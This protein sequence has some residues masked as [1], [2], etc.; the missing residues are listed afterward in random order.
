MNRLVGGFQFNTTATVESGRPLAF[1]GG[2]SSPMATR[3]NLDPS[4]LKTNPSAYTL[5]KLRRF[6]YEAFTDPGYVSGTTANYAFGN[7]PRYYA[8]LRGPGVLNFDMSIF[9]TTNITEK[10]SL[11]L[12]LEAFNAFNRTN[13]G[14]P[15]TGFSA[16]TGGVNSNNQMGVVTTSL[17]ARQ[18]QLAAKLHF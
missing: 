7:A 9:K 3:P 17:N 15:S 2:G 5:S 14:T 12:R 10:T 4:K 11:E 13:L 1:S 18:V 8:K 6:N 16:G